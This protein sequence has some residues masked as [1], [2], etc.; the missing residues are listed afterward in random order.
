LQ[1]AYWT[2]PFGESLLQIQTGKYETPPVPSYSAAFGSFI[3]YL[4]NPSQSA[5][6]DV[7]Q[8]SELLH[9]TLLRGPNPVP[10]LSNSKPPPT[11]AEIDEAAK[12]IEI[13]VEPTPTKKIAEV[14][15]VVLETSVTPR[16]RPKGLGGVLQPPKSPKIDRKV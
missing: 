13:I 6:P 4:L 10:N 9:T 12:K 14:S 15:S 16:Q 2:L 5:R 11:L 8:V 7:W 1:V 3:R